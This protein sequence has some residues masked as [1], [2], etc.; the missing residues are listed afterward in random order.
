MFFSKKHFLSNSA[1]S[2]FIYVLF[3]VTFSAPNSFTEI[4]IHP[5]TRHLYNQF[6]NNVFEIS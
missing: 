5:L 2:C 1:R 3:G 4:H 6:P